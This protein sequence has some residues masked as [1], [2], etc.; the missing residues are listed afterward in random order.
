MPVLVTAASKYGSTAEIAER[1]A[2]VLTREGVECRVAAAE[3]VTSVDGVDAVVLGS[4]IY[5]GHWL[6]GAVHVVDVIRRATSKPAVWLFTSGPIGPPAGR[7]A[8]LM[9]RTDAAELAGAITGTA[10]REHRVFPGK[11]DRR[12]L[13][14]SQRV[15]LALFRRMD[16]DFRDWPA[17]EAWARSIAG[18]L[19]TG[20]PG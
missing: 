8:R 16:G 17:V 4:A 11:L 15:M 18:D 9:A 6:P 13:R 3:E 2:Q 7:F 20:R 1:I 19:V 14:G 12:R 5:A 10:A